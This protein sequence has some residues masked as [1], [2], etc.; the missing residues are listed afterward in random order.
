MAVH[1]QISGT[2][3]ETAFKDLLLFDL[4]IVVFDF[5]H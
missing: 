1:E 4:E 3:L 2:C 5:L